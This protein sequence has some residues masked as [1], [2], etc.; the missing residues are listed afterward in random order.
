MYKIIFEDGKKFIGGEPNS[1]KWLEIPN[2]PIKKLE[3]KLFGKTI[4]LEN[5]RAY[6]HIVK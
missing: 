1:S 5:Y 3:Y 2:K 6:N 4:I